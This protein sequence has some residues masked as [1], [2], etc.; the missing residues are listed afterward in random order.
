MV[1]CIQIYPD[2]LSLFFSHPFGD[3]LGRWRSTRVTSPRHILN[4]WRRDGADFIRAREKQKK[5]VKIDA[6][7]T[8]VSITLPQQKRV[9]NRERKKMR[10]G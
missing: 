7:E 3:N 8:R 2:V 10:E 1:R 9:R 4:D 6:K 5:I